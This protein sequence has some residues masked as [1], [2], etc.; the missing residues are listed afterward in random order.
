MSILRARASRG[1]SVLRPRD[2]PRF[3]L[4]GETLLTGLIVLV[5]SLP[6]VT[7]LPAVAAGARHL[8]RHVTGESDRIRD[9]VA[10]LG[11]AIR[12]LWL[13]GLVSGLVALF[14]AA[15]V[16]ALRAFAVPGAAA[17]SV[18]LAL[19]GAAGAVVLLRFAGS[20][21]PDAPVRAQLRRAALESTA[22]GTGSMLLLL[23]VC[24]AVLLVWMFPAFALLVGG[25]LSLA[26]YSVDAR[27]E[28]LSAME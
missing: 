24:G 16:V 18:V 10:D 2:A 12:R 4:F 14:L 22:D 3:A 15:D 9:L 13:P 27:L 5:A 11:L 20:W 19:A 28:A 1:R 7:A 26:S 21:A 6:V 8:R 17:V 23:A 25:L